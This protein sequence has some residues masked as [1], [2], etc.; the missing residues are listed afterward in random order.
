MQELV[1]R[2]GRIVEHARR[3]A[4]GLDAATVPPLPSPG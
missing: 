4:L 1:Y 3:F 2:A